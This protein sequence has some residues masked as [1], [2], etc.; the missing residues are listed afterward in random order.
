[1]P[2][3]KA[4]SINN[5]AELREFLVEKMID[6]AEDKI[7]AQAAKSITSLAQ[8]VHNSL[9]LEMDMARF[10]SMSKALEA[11]PPEG[12]TGVTPLSLISK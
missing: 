7:T 8:Q 1:M 10:V 12:A 11:D 5:T 3:K 2:T 6:V 9:R 4:T